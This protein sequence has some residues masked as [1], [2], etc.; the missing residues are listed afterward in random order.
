M[1]LDGGDDHEEMAAKK[2]Q[3]AGRKEARR[4]DVC[5]QGE[6]G[7]G[8]DWYQSATSPYQLPTLAIESLTTVAC[9]PEARSSTHRSVMFKAEEKT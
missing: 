5:Q 8:H 2:R 6:E 1:N 7:N 3:V 4:H 9:K